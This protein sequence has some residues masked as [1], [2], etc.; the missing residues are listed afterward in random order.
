MEVAC[1]EYSANG[2]ARLDEYTRIIPSCL[3]KSDGFS[4]L[5]DIIGMNVSP[6]DGKEFAIDID[7][8]HMR[9]R[10]EFRHALT[11]DNSG[12]P[13]CGVFDSRVLDERR[14]SQSD[15]LVRIVHDDQGN[16]GWRDDPSVLHS[17][18]PPD[19]PERHCFR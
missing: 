19:V 17:I 15:V 14:R 12:Q 10:S 11:T 3:L 5:Q 16:C 6:V 18:V 1:A 7:I 9:V 4:G 13:L 2:A 8:S